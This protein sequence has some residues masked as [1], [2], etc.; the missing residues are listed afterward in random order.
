MNAKLIATI[1]LHCQH[2]AR[3]RLTDPGALVAQ[4]GAMQAQDHANALWAIGL[5]TAGADAVSVRAAIADRR[6][7]RSWVLRGTLHCVAGADL[8]WMLALLGERSIA[9]MAG[10]HRGLGLDDKLFAACAKL[11]VKALAGGKQMTRPALFALLDDAGIAT[12]GQRGIHILWRLAQQGLL[13]FGDHAGKQPTFALLDDWLPAPG[14]RYTRDEALAELAHRYATSHGPASAA[15]FAFWAGIKLSDARLG[16]AAGEGLEQV[17]ADGV[18]YW[19]A[20]GAAEAS[21]APGG[22]FLLPGFDEYLLGYKDRGAVLAA[23]H[24]PRIAPGGNGV[25]KPMIVSGGRIVG[26][27]QRAGAGVGTEPFIALKRRRHQGD[28]GRSARG[29][30]LLDRENM[31][32]RNY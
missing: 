7:V 26:T 15:D 23:E 25:F 20:P 10:R 16:L 18:R 4:M 24:A 5:R 28:R 17:E 11:V 21:A 22:V 29:V 3:P 2:I 14:P 32:R 30:R 12:T 1:R 31:T 8:R 13:C 19:M 9:G 6:I 27:W